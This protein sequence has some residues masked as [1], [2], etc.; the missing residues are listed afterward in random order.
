MYTHAYW[1]LLNKNTDRLSSTY[2]YVSKHFSSINHSRM[3]TNILFVQ[4]GKASAGQHQCSTVGN[5]VNANQGGPV[6][7][8]VTPGLSWVGETTIGDPS[9]KQQEGTRLWRAQAPTQPENTPPPHKHTAFQGSRVRT[10][11][12]YGL[13]IR[14]LFISRRKTTEWWR[15]F[16]FR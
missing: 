13:E 10:H 15:P 5:N 8:K 11:L 6:P 9:A 7:D 1:H 2:I 16:S 14:M 4:R 3:Y 12:K